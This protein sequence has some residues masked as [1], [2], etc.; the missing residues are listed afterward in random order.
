MEQ[1]ENGWWKKEF[2]RQFTISGKIKHE[3]PL[4]GVY[5]TFIRWATKPDPDTIIAFI[6][7]VEQ[8]ARKD[9]R[10]R[11]LKALIEQ[12]EPYDNA[13]WHNQLSIETV[14]KIVKGL[15]DNNK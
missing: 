13:K 9:E 10:E 11:V 6:S 3:T 7:Q 14:K 4:K 5:Q 8:D 12:A 1:K 2:D 15:S